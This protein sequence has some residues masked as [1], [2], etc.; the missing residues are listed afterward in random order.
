MLEVPAQAPAPPQPRFTLTLRALSGAASCL[1]AITGAAK[2]ETLENARH[3]HLPVAAMIAALQP[4]ILW[5][6]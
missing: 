3:G 2:R 4:R 1:L 5:A 6:Q